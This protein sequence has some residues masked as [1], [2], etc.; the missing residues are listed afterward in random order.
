MLITVFTPTFNRAHTIHRVY[1]S[2]KSQT[3]KDFEWI[4]VDDGST[5]ET[6]Q[7][8]E[9]WKQ[10]GIL[11]IKYVKQPNKGKF[12]TLIETLFSA[13]GDWFLI[14]DSDDSFVPTTI[15]TFLN[16]YNSIPQNI[17]DKIAGVTGLVMDSKDKRVIGKPFPIDPKVGYMIASVNEI[18]Y[19]YGIT[20]EKWGILKTSVLQEF[21]K[22]IVIPQNVKYIGEQ[23][24]WASV[25]DK[26]LTVFINTPLRIY[27]QGSSDSLSNRNITRRHPMGA[28]IT[29]RIVL[30]FIF[31]YFIYHPKMIL[32]S[33]IKLNYASYL[34]NKSFHETVNG[35]P[36]ALYILMMLMRP[37]GFL[38]KI[39][40]PLS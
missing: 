3:I 14:A 9:S 30:P 12:I 32:F 23:A 39:I 24:L 38:A 31:Q 25:G 40:Y 1:N 20:G 26:Y 37:I 11:P 2:L 8:I 17:H 5:D 16:T 4:I 33:A 35:F 10:E 13:K 36:C 7:L 28:W 27:F 15:E 6:G 22:K 29:E 34:A 19:K 18:T 21:A